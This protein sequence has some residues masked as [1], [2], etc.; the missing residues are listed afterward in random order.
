MP[1]KGHNSYK[2]NL[3]FSSS[4]FQIPHFIVNIH[5][6][7]Q[8]CILSNGRDMTKCQFFIDDDD[9]IDDAKAIAIPWVF[10]ENSRGKN[11]ENMT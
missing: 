2:M 1:K 4:F 5:F 9:N 3:E 8:A 10:S 11:L 7:F 6:E